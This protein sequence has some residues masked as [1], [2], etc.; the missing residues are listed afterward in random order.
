MNG[1]WPGQIGALL[2]G[3]FKAKPNTNYPTHSSGYYRG[4]GQHASSPQDRNKTT[5]S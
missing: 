5:N 4:E 1:Y 2:V 3:Y